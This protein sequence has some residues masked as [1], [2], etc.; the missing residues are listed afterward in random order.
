V[1]LANSTTRGFGLFS[2]RERLALLGGE[3]QIHSAPGK[4]TRATVTVPA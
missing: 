1:T 2:I 3:L 4:G